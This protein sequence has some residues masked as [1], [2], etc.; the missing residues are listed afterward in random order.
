MVGTFVSG[1]YHPEGKAWD[2]CCGNKHNCQ[3]AY[4]KY[5]TNC[6]SLG[7][8]EPGQSRMD[9]TEY[10]L[11]YSDQPFWCDHRV[12]NQGYKRVCAGYATKRRE[13]YNKWLN[14]K[15]S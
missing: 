5:K 7:S 8:L 6:A 9:V 2:K 14:E 3:C 15:N 4:R 13:L 11:R 12:D 10:D 1:H